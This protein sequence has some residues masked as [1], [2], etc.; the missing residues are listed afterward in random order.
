MVLSEV[1]LKKLSKDEVINLALD[2]QGKFDS[3]LAGTRKRSEILKKNL[4]SLDQNC[5]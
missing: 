3:N 2:Y 1:A 5:Y 4:R